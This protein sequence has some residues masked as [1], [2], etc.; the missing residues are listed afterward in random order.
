VGQG[1]PGR[2]TGRRRN[3]AAALFAL[4]SVAGAASGQSA[5]CNQARAIVAEARRSWEAGAPNHAQLLGRLA[6]ARDLCPANG[7]AWKY[8][9]CSAKALG[10]TRRSQ[11]YR[12]RALFNGVSQVECAGTAA[13]APEPLPSF[14]RRKFALIVGIGEFADPAI[15]KLR[16]AAKDATDLRDVLIAPRVGNFDRGDVYLHTDEQATRANILKSLHEIT[17]RAREDDLV[18]LFFSSHGSPRRDRQGLQGIGYIAAYDTSWKEMYLNS[19]EFEDLSKKVSLIAARRK[20]TLLDTCYSG[21]SS[22]GGGKALVLEGAGVSGPTANLFLSGEGS[23]VITSSQEDEISYESETLQNGYFTHFLVE[24]LRQ[25]SEPPT[26]QQVFRH[27]ADRVQQAVAR[28]RH[29]SQRPRLL[30]EDGRG[31]VRIGVLST[32]E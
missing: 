11:I 23:Y 14:V 13:A 9:Y 24:A 4:A 30:P 26:V 5:A 25:G 20:V 31:E 28:E 3:L 18:L 19:I 1:E 29:A 22:V 6:M 27:L 10:D 16:F 32:P 2:R 8:S 7:E 15:P 17:L 21:Q 12:D